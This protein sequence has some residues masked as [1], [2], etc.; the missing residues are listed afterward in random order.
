MTPLILGVS[1]WNVRPSA[2]PRGRRPEPQSV[3]RRRS[4]LGREVIDEKG[5]GRGVRLRK[6]ARPKGATIRLKEDQYR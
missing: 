3:R 2:S 4:A 5:G 1:C 6:R